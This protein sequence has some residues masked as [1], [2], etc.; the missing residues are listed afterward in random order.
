[1]YKHMKFQ[2]AIIVPVFVLNAIQTSTLL[3]FFIS[4]WIADIYG[5]ED[6]GMIASSILWSLSY[7]IYLPMEGMTIV[8]QSLVGIWVLVG[9]N[10]FV[11]AVSAVY[12]V[13]IDDEQKKMKIVIILGIILALLWL[14][15]QMYT[16][17]SY[18]Y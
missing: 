6:P 13:K 15:I 11:L 9:V 17:N 14:S 8:Y 10:V 1:M 12:L 3:I 7:F 16:L 2:R 18:T 4:N 5:K